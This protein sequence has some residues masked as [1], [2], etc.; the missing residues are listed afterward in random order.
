[1]RERV[2]VRVSVHSVQKLLTEALLPRSRDGA[3]QPA[4]P[5]GAAAALKAAERPAL[6]V[7]RQGRWGLARVLSS[8]LDFQGAW[9]NPTLTVDL[10]YHI[11]SFCPFSDQF[12]FASVSPRSFLFTLPGF[13]ERRAAPFLT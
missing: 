6:S 4:A 12:P 7:C 2:H 11:M 9:L 3:P 13:R 10:P 1:M 5:A 8:P